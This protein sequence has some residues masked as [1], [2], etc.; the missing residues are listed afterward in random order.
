[1][2]GEGLPAQ[3][4]P[5]STFVL[6]SEAIPCVP[7]GLG[8]A[9]HLE[10]RLLFVQLQALLH[11]RVSYPIMLTVR[12]WIKSYWTLKKIHLFSVSRG[13]AHTCYSVRM[14]ARRRLTVSTS[15]LAF[16]YVSSRN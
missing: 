5:T 12:C 1:M 7:V 15:V 4:M 3:L 16:Y 2:K 11:P 13:V 14:E 8:L 10:L 9:Y 6:R